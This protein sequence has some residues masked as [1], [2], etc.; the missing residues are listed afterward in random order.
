M[1]AMPF[2]K[3]LREQRQRNLR[4]K[5]RLVRL[6]EHHEAQQRLILSQQAEANGMLQNVTSA[7]STQYRM[8]QER[9][10][11]SLLRQ[12]Q[13]NMEKLVAAIVA[14]GGINAQ[15]NPAPESMQTNNEGHRKRA[16]VEGKVEVGHLT[17]KPKQKK[18]HHRRKSL[19]AHESVD[20]VVAHAQKAHKD[21]THS[22]H[23]QENS[24]DASAPKPEVHTKKKLE[25]VSNLEELSFNELLEVEDDELDLSAALDFS[26]KRKT[27]EEIEREKQKLRLET[28]AKLRAEGKMA[29]A[30]N[31]QP[32]WRHIIDGNPNPPPES[33]LKGKA[34]LRAS[35]MY[36]VAAHYMKRLRE[37]RDLSNRMTEE[38][39]NVKLLVTLTDISKA[40]FAKLIRVPVKSITDDAKLTMDV[41]HDDLGTR[42]G[43]LATIKD[44]TPLKQRMLRLKVRAKGI[45]DR[46]TYC[47]SIEHGLNM[48]VIN[49]MVTLISAKVYWPEG[50]LFPGELAMMDYARPCTVTMDQDQLDDPKGRKLF[51]KRVQRLVLGILIHRICFS[52]VLLEPKENGIGN[53][54]GK[55]PKK[56]IRLVASVMY[57]LL[58][59]IYD[60]IPAGSLSGDGLV[61]DEHL[62]RK[63]WLLNLSQK[64]MKNIGEEE[65]DVDDKSK[66]SKKD[67]KKA[68]E[69]GKGKPATENGAQKD[70]GETVTDAEKDKSLAK[71]MKQLAKDENVATALVAK[72]IYAEGFDV[73]LILK[74]ISCEVDMTREGEKSLFLPKY[75]DLTD[76]HICV[77]KDS[78]RTINE[79]LFPLIEGTELHRLPMLPKQLVLEHVDTGGDSNSSRGGK[80]T[81]R[82][83]TRYH[84]AAFESSCRRILRMIH[85]DHDMAIHVPFHQEDLAKKFFPFA[86]FAA[87]GDA[88]S[89]EWMGSLK[90]KLEQWAAALAEIIVQRLNPAEAAKQDEQAAQVKDTPRI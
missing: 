72:N 81:I 54:Q 7:I 89:E 28:Q 48:T 52:S 60:D 87:A 11:R 88:L 66:K 90:T 3:R 59:M 32:K 86:R 50:Y 35:V 16:N 68:V 8:R 25:E 80:I 77:F 45:I 49:L 23:R 74:C 44:K 5:S 56:N 33:I 40:W 65:K 78:G 17:E 29:K 27:K 63:N 18:A 30:K 2:S 53:P 14:G 24:G 22:I 21:P 61:E 1:S 20:D 10:E 41:L 4:L 58:I 51:L 55:L 82:F 38:K 46:I 34:L 69:G 79:G 31:L 71:T 36:V 75:V 42:F 85:P 19:V 73:K 12:Q 67:K 6:K 9:E 37:E 57:Q 13:Q 70:S 26:K 62:G 39:S 15:K 47:D 84:R 76:H 83:D 43:G 64:R